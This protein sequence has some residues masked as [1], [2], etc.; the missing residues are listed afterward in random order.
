MDS[1][2][3]FIWVAVALAAL[4]VIFGVL[5]LATGNAGF[6]LWAIAPIAM[7]FATVVTALRGA[8]KGERKR[9]RDARIA[10]RKAAAKAHGHAGN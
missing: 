9:D 5:S 2:K 1:R 4:L 3:T 8:T 10:A 6:I 7:A